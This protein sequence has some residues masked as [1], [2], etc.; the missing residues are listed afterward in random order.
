[1]SQY[2]V[3]AIDGPAAS[4]KSSVARSLAARL[5]F[6]YVNSG[7]MYRALT[8]LAIQQNLDPADAEAVV[9][10][11]RKSHISCRLIDG[12]SIIEIDGVNPED[13]LHEQ[14]I[15]LHVSAVAAIPEVRLLLLDKLRAFAEESN[16]VMEGRDIGSTVF[17]GTPYKFYIDASETVRAKRRAH[18]G[19]LDSIAERDRADS[20]R[21]A[22]PLTVAPGAVMI[23]S[24]HLDVDGVVNEILSH[25]AKLNPEQFSHT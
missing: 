7:G 23:D 5:G 18:Q 1:M 3:I 12:R 24:T 14:K 20:S 8:W 6:A 4:G 2:L 11:G 21:T 17:P 15:N 16:L 19:Q 10:A 9:T 22:S 13:S 25:L